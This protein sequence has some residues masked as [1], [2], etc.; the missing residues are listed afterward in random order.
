[1]PSAWIQ[2]VK[3]YASQHNITY[4]EAL[5]LSKPSYSVYG[6]VS[7]DPSMIKLNLN[8]DQYN[9]SAIKINPAFRKGEKSTHNVNIKYKSD[10]IINKEGKP[11]API[12]QQNLNVD[13]SP[14][15]KINQQKFNNPNQRPKR[16]TPEYTERPESNIYDVNEIIEPTKTRNTI[17]Q[18]K[19]YNPNQRPKRQ[20]PEYTERPES[21][22]Y[23]VNEIIEPTKTRNKFIINELKHKKNIQKIEA[24]YNKI[25]NT[26]MSKYINKKPITTKPNESKKNDRFNFLYEPASIE[27]PKLSFSAPFIKLIYDEGIVPYT[28]I[29]LPKFN[30]PAEEINIYNTII[31][32]YENLV[33]VLLASGMPENDKQT[34]MN[35]CRENIKSLKDKILKIN[36]EQTQQREQEQM[37]MND[38]NVSYK[39]K[40][41]KG[42]TKRDI[43]TINELLNS[44]NPISL[45]KSDFKTKKE[46]IDYFSLIYKNIDNKR[47][48]YNDMDKPYKEIKILYDNLNK[49][50]HTIDRYRDDIINKE[51]HVDTLG[52]NKEKKERDIID[53]LMNSDYP[54]LMLRSDFKTKDEIQRYFT[55]LSNK[56]IEKKKSLNTNNSLSDKVKEAR[57]YDELQ[58]KLDKQSVVLV[59][60]LKATK[61][62]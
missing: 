48:D 47:I 37:G 32:K 56:I 5:K 41:N 35:E 24:K 18:H 22:I 29:I 2:H 20:T 7:T 49:L 57:L 17:I 16:Q 45:L 14:I 4:K 52:Q 60:N 6:T 55:G 42:S 62:N 58:A 36:N 19:I 38:I 27:I 25:K 53:D 30:S 12:S 10:E 21:N 39:P 13:V 26:D 34:L 9:L 8:D 61:K 54:M 50:L 3:R 33:I 23:D 44:D 15:I 28:N 46:R 40:K 1:M 11:K 59:K 31:I 43:P 51:I